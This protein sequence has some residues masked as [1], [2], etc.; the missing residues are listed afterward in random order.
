M[1][2]VT[3]QG[4]KLTGVRVLPIAITE[5]EKAHQNGTPLLAEG[6]D[7]RRMI[8]YIA[9]ASKEFGTKID[10]KSGEVDLGA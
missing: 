7:A 2:Q 6:E 3:F 4:P 8:E 5:G 9:E 1:G 10:V